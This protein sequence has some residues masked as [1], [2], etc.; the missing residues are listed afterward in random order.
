MFGLWTDVGELTRGGRRLVGGLLLL[1]VL[2]VGLMC[3]SPQ[4]DISG[5]ET[6]G[7]HYYGRVPVLLMPLNSLVRFGDVSSLGQ[8]V[9]IFCQ[10]AM[11]ILLLFPL[12]FLAL[13]LF[14]EIRSWEK[15]GLLALALSLCIECGQVLLDVLFDFNRV[16]EVD[17]LWTNTLGGLIAYL[18]Y[19][20]LHKRIKKILQSNA[21][22]SL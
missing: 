19:S 13:W 21:N 12:V 8:L 18:L 2:A 4:I 3:F 9:W 5:I 17:D 20:G 7:I 14:P 15:S 6:P 1:Y 11:N 22:E 10:N 16:F